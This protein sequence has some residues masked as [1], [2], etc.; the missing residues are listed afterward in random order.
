[1]TKP[2]IVWI[3]PDEWRHDAFGFAGNEVIQTPNVDAL[4]RRGATFLGARCES[5]VCQSARASLL[6]G[7][8]AA[9]H[10]LTDNEHLPSTKGA[11]PA[12][13]EPN[14]LHSL[15]AAGYRTAEV[16]KMH[17]GRGSLGDGIRAW[18]FDDAWQEHDKYVLWRLD[19]PYTRHLRE[20]GLWESWEQ[21]NSGLLPWLPSVDGKMQPNPRFVQGAEAQPDHV[22]A[23]EMLDVFI[24]NEACRHIADHD[25]DQPFFLWVAPIGPHPPFDAP[26]T[27]TDRYAPEMIPL[28]SLAREPY[29]DNEWGRYLDWNL[30]HIG[31]GSWTEDRWRRI[32]AQYYGLCNQVD[33]IV[34]RIVATLAETGLDRDTWIVFSSDHGELLGDHG[35]FSKR[36]FYESSVR[37]PQLIVPPVGQERPVTVSGMT[38]A[39]DTVA[40]ILDIA[41]ATWQ[42]DDVPARSLLPALTGEPCERDAV[43][44]QIAGFAM[45]ATATQKVVVHEESGTVGALYDL[46]EDP[47]E[48]VNL[49]DDPSARSA[50]SDLIDRTAAFLAG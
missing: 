11:F 3:F 28:G 7:L 24:G 13:D 29:P 46:A 37:V 34:G 4:A 45:A 30:N 12:A 25:G 23:E 43:F 41:G 22:P 21:H 10:G 27:Y 6:T 49:V 31:C 2:N 47:G 18:G 14:F 8:Y 38:Q 17:F 19:T 33:D 35:L 40:T 50:F 39:F 26:R 32:G 48:R 5:P 1:M 16:G 42:R 15:R 36:V 9:Q 20:L 44:S